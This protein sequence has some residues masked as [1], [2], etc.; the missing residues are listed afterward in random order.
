MPYSLLVD[1][2]LLTTAQFVRDPPTEPD[3]GNY[4]SIFTSPLSSRIAIM[5]EFSRADAILRR[6]KV[7]A[8]TLGL[9]DKIDAVR[10]HI[11]DLQKQTVIDINKSRDQIPERHNQG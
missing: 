8:A 2:F 3:C 5:A 1:P 9:V 6:A 11:L 7:L 4:V 10:D